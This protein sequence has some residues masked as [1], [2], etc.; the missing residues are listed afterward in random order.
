MLLFML[1]PI[2]ALIELH[3]TLKQ[4]KSKSYENCRERASLHMGIFFV[5][6]NF[7]FLQSNQISLNEISRS[8]D[9]ILHIL[10]S[11]VSISK[12]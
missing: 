12:L 2:K 9:F 5:S 6:M 8:A 4:R 7:D 1:D 10:E 11:I 3:S